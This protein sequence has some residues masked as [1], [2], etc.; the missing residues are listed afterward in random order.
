MVLSTEGKILIK[1]R[2]EKG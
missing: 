2:Q 1:A